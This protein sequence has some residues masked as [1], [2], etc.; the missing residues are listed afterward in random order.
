MHK[1]DIMGSGYWRLRKGLD[2]LRQSGCQWDLDLNSKLES[3]G[4]R[5]IEP[6]WSVHV[7]MRG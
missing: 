6:D 5:H 1:P 2:G 3:I 7:R 4:F